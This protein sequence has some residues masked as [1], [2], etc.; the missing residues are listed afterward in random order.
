MAKINKS[1]FIKPKA[2]AQWKNQSAEM[3][4]QLTEWEKIFSNHVSNKGLIF[5]TYKELIQL[6]SNNNQ[7]QLKTEQK[8]W[9]AIQMAIRYLK[10]WSLIIKKMQIKTTMRYHLTIIRLATIKKKRWQVLVRIWGKGTF[11]FCWL[12]CKLVQPLWKIVWH[13]LKKLNIEAPYELSISLLSIYPKEM[14]IRY[15]RDICTHMFTEAYSQ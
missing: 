2:S 5:I 12:E 8:N 7:S 1:N 14:K 10:R 11:G 6:N 9:I 3:K 13:F 15:W 4:R